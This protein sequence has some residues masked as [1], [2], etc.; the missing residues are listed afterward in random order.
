MGDFCEVFIRVLVAVFISSLVLI[1][2]TVGIEKVL[3]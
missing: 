2:L 1:W 3:H